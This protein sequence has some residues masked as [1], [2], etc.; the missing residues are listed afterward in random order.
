MKRMKCTALESLIAL[1]VEGD[2]PVLDRRR[3]DFHLQSC[4]ACNA[5][6]E[7]LR[8]SQSMFK[9]LRVATVN[10]SDLADVRKRVLNEVGDLEPAPG[11]VVTMHRLFFA[12]VRR[13]NAIAGVLLMALVTGSIWYSQWHVDGERKNESPVAVAKFEVPPSGLVSDVVVPLANLDPVVKRVPPV[14]VLEVLPV[15]EPE[16]QLIDEPV[17]ALESQVSQIPMKF[18]TDD[19][20]IIIY[21]LPADKGD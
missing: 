17:V 1:Y 14:Q 2:L 18:V 9:V 8:E 6:A 11:W 10:V 5:L 3:V 20:N 4:T 19:P 7:N 16:V 12:G 13:R 15:K 21:W